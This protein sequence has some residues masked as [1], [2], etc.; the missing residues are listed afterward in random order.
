MKKILK[1]TLLV[2]GLI[3]LA[4]GLYINFNTYAPQSQALEAMKEANVSDLKAYYVIEGEKVEANLIF[5]PGGFVEAESYAVL[6]QMLSSA[7]IRT[8]IV[9]PP[10]NLAIL[11]TSAYKDIMQ[12]H[13]SDAPWF[14]GGHSLGGSSAIIG[15]D[16][17]KGD[18][19][20]LIL[21]AS[22]GTEAID[23][24][25]SDL[26][27]LSIR[28]SN[29]LVLDLNTY[30]LRKS[31]LPD[32]TLYELIDG[33]NHSGFGFYGDQRKDGKATISNEDQHEETSQLIIDFMTKE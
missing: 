4:L 12:A 30:K 15:Y 11:N 19:D 31:S 14:L 7:H 23:L 20:G 21:L 6:G 5:Y 8:F 16:K 10:L 2:L 13:P 29:D 17:H 26:K 33:G 22:Y 24:S 3:L 1:Y 9:K 28:A 32:N 27:V 25:N 18:V